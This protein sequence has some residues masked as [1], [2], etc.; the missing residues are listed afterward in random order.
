MTDPDVVAVSVDERDSAWERDDPTFRVYL[1][2][3]GGAGTSA[4]TDTYDI[5]GADV[6]QV[7]EWARAQAG[8]ERSCAV[9]LVYDD[10]HLEQVTPG[11]G[12]GLVWLLW[13]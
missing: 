12:R 3:L 10:A 8:V 4:N 6:L 2:T 7:V 5:T 13:A 9:A 11:A 1:Q